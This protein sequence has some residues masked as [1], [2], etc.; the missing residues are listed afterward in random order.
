MESVSP[1]IVSLHDLACAIRRRWIMA[2]LSLAGAAT[3]IAFAKAGAR[4]SLT[5]RN[6]E[7]LTEV[8]RQCK[9]KP[10]DRRLRTILT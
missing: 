10:R 3:S 9:F 2:G 5:G 8:S 6:M 4:L 1:H 7:N